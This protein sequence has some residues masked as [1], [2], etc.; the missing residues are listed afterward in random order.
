MNNMRRKALQEIIE[1]L[2]ELNEKIESL[3]NDEYESF[4]NIPENLISTERY[5][6]AES[7]VENLQSA[8][9]SVNDSVEY[10]NC[11]IV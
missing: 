1:Q 10:I 7:A 8:M 11:A 5:E 4:E 6:K 2:E 9:D 3:Y